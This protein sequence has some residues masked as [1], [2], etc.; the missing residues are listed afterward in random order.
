M[1]L[2]CNFKYNGR[3]LWEEEIEDHHCRLGQFRQIDHDQPTQTE[4][5]K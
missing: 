5:V 1:T 3:L 2:H 4:K